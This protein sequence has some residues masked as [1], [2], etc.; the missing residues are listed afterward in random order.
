MRAAEQFV[1]RLAVTVA[2][3]QLTEADLVRILTEP[4]NAI[5]KQYQALFSMSNVRPPPGPPPFPADRSLTALHGAVPAR[6]YRRWLARTGGR[7]HPQKDGCAR[8][9][10]HRGKAGPIAA[11]CA[12]QSVHAFTVRI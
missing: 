2:V 10:L 1:G 6:F 9:A 11:P 7:G 4:R 8:P 5:T 3:H 12:A